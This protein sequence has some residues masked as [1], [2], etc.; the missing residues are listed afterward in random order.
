MTGRADRRT[1]SRL[2][3][4]ASSL[5]LLAV[6]ASPAAA[7]SVLIRRVD[8]PRTVANTLALR[9]PGAKLLELRRDSDRQGVRHYQAEMNVQGQRVGAKFGPRGKWLEE[10]SEIRFVDAP[11]AVRT[12]F[13][14][15]SSRGYSLERMERATAADRRAAQYEILAAHPGGDRLLV[16]DAAGKMLRSTGVAAAD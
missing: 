11:A 5:L 16:L 2:A 9:Y 7:K 6:L 1:M 10:R 13:G 8:L 15:Y 3:R 4:I 14:W 12:A